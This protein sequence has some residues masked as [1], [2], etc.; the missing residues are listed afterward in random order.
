MKHDELPRQAQDENVRKNAENSK[1]IVGWYCTR[2]YY[3]TKTKVISVNNGWDNQL[4]IDSNFR[5]VTFGAHSVSL[6]RMEQKYGKNGLDR[7]LSG[8]KQ[9]QSSLSFF[10]FVFSFQSL[11]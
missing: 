7:Y 6:T 8:A 4:A 2:S 9:K 3:A 10:L 5:P 1:A 11:I